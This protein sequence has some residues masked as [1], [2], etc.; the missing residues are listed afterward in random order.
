MITTI[1]KE[2]FRY[3]KGEIYALNSASVAS[4]TE[5]IRGKIA[6]RRDQPGHRDKKRLVGHRGREEYWRDSL[7]TRR[8]GETLR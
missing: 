4:S 3:T 6:R 7:L 2:F 1:V 5:G 8:R